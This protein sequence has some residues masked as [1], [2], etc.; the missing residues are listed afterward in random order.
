MSVEERLER[1]EKLL[2]KIAGETVEQ[3][4]LIDMRAA[5]EI[6]GL[7]TA[8]LYSYISNGKMNIPVTKIGKK[9]TFKRKDLTAWIADRSRVV[10]NF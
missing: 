5:S 4:E 3:D 2:L 8:T 7:S 1:I 10:V 9:V 6:T